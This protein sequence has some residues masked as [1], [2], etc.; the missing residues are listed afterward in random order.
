MKTKKAEKSI[1]YTPEQ[2]LQFV[3]DTEKELTKQDKTDM[4][5]LRSALRY[6]ESVLQ[7]ISK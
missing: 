3:Q 5:R 6:L 4:I 1:V 2:I 7:E